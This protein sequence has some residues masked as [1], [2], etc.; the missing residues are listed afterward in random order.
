M[1]RWRFP[2]DIISFDRLFF[3]LKTGRLGKIKISQPFVICGAFKGD[4]DE[5][6]HF[7]PHFSIRIFHAKV[8][9]IFCA[10]VRIPKIS[11]TVITSI[12]DTA[13]FPPPYLCLTKQSTM[14]TTNDIR[15][16]I[17][18]RAQLLLRYNDLLATQCENWL[19]EAEGMKNMEKSIRER[20][21]AQRKRRW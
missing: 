18:M 6:A 10:R 9:I 15:K 2:S 12:S 3:W 17:L 4:S 8:S 16:E 13:C 11:D 20:K 1:A 19:S 14:R 5:I 7:D 21:R